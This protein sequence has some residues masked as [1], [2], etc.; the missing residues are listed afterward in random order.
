MK[1]G[2]Y[3]LAGVAAFAVAVALMLSA[4]STPTAEAA[5]QMRNTDGSYATR[6][7][8]GA[9]NNGDVVY[10]QNA[11]AGFVLYE[12]TA[13]GNADASFTHASA[14]NN[15][16]LLYCSPV[17]TT[18]T[19]P[20]CDVDIPGTG[21]TVAVKVANDSGRGGIIIKQT[22]LADGTTTADELN[23]TV[24]PVPTRLAPSASPKAVNAGEGTATAGTSTLTFRLTDQNGR[25]IGGTGLTIIASHGTL[26]TATAP[27]A[28]TDSTGGVAFT[29]SG[30]QVGT[31]STS[32]DGGGDADVDG[33]GNAA[34]TFTAGG[35]PGTAT[36]TARVSA[37]TL[38][39]TVNV[40]MYGAAKAITAV[41]EQSALQV[42]GSTFIVVTVTDA[43]DNPVAEHNVAV[44]SGASGV[45]GPSPGSREV[46]PSNI[47]MKNAAPLATL[48]GTDLPACGDVAAVADTSAADEPSNAVAGS[49]G[50][51]ADGKCVIQVATTGG[52]TATTADDTARGTH[53]ITIAGPASDGSADV[54]VEI[55]IGG[56]PDVIT[57][58]A[59]AQL[60]PGEEV[61]INVTVV[62]D[63]GVR[64]GAV[65]IEALKTDG[66]GLITTP[67][68]AMTSDGRAK[69]A[70]LAPSRPG[71]V[72]LLVRTKTDKGAETARL[73]IT[74]Q[75]GEVEPPAQPV[76]VSGQSG[77]V[78]VQNAGSIEDILGALA[79]GS[80]TGTTV[81]LPGN[82]IYAVGA[83]AVV[84]A[85]F[86]AN[87][88]FPI[89][90]A[91]AYVSC[92]G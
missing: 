25:G 55:E 81:T 73:P 35:V 32:T 17:A 47:V 30:T 62:D 18:A 50:T 78:V 66:G 85:G 87:V 76:S 40:T 3:G 12:I 64:V 33:A 49:N 9:V 92:G 4:S 68:R 38:S 36:I 89:E 11:A 75:I 44:K 15:G 5:I 39:N 70:Y 63:E 86:L 53:T 27:A 21:T 2:A 71:S 46:V 23:V 24:S 37:G 59:P 84:N 31:V 74:I 88:S 14:Q 28:W 8:G 69:F 77:L 42:G 10:I 79:C 29:G 52:D 90:L 1:L 67:I 48:T 19:A 41:P 7:G 45:V 54:T 91:A 56:A 60:E 58:D 83:P 13:I 22:V 34:V 43:G 20:T 6:T 82:N 26:D 61:T 57:S 16:Q 65:A 80:T 51:N 72:D